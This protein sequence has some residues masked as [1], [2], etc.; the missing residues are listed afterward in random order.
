L[1]GY[2]KG[3]VV[4]GDLSAPVDINLSRVSIRSAKSKGSNR[5]TLNGKNNKHISKNDLS[6]LF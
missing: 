2:K 5:S 1:S 6:S 3:G 4:K